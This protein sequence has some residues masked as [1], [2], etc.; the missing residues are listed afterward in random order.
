M[1]DPHVA[2]KLDDWR[3]RR[4]Q[5]QRGPVPVSARSQPSDDK[6]RFGRKGDD[7]DDED[8]A[9][10]GMSV[11]LRDLRAKETA[12]WRGTNSQTTLRQRKG[13]STNVLDEVRSIMSVTMSELT[14]LLV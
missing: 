1:Y 10:D 14:F 11:E 13:K 4:R 6:A 3:E 2:P 8:D 9:D 5:R 7:S 12:E